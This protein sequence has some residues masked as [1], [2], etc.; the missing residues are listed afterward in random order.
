M[1]DN[2]FDRYGDFFAA[3]KLFNTDSK[4]LP[5]ELAKILKPRSLTLSEKVVHLVRRDKNGCLSPCLLPVA[6]H[7]DLACV[8]SVVFHL[9]FLLS[10]PYLK[11]SGCYSL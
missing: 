10:F 5:K 11:P 4:R 8:L 1:R 7:V 6:G 3:K 9:N 2:K